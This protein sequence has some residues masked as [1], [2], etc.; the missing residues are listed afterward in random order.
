VALAHG[1]GLFSLLL[2]L[3]PAV[4]LRLV[5][6]VR[7]WWVSGRRR[8]AVVLSLAFGFAFLLGFALVLT[9]PA[10][11]A[12]AAYTYDVHDFFAVTLYRTLFDLPTAP[13]VPGLW[14]L[15]L[16]TVLGAVVVARRSELAGVRW[17][18]WSAGAV[19][20]VA[21]AAAGGLGPLRILGGPWYSQVPRIVAV[22]P[23]VAAP[24]AAIGLLVLAGWVRRRWPGIRGAAAILV[25]VAFVATVG[26]SAPWKAER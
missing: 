3:L 26:W 21:M 11:R 25:V 13:T 22:F 10:V 1:A 7:H 9:S 14:P 17:L 20:V 2:V 18:V 8:A 12:V 5:R 19:L 4:L 16:L 6:G 24:L 15:A 23:V